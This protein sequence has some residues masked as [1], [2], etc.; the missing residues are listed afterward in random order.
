MTAI[1]VSRFL[2][3]LQDAGQRSAARLLGGTQDSTDLESS[4]A[5]T[6]HSVVFARVIGSVAASIRPSTYLLSAQSELSMDAGAQDTD[7]GMADNRLDKHGSSD[8]DAPALLTEDQ[9]AIVDVAEV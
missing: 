3:D 5:L 8:I 1:L 4:G 6:S 2:L 7:C 9:D